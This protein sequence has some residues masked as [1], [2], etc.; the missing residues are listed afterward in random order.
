MASGG[1]GLNGEPS[2]QPPSGAED[3]EVRRS[4][5]RPAPR[6]T[7]F[8]PRKRANTACQVCRA[9]KTK[10][11]NKKPSCTY[12]LSVGAKC[13]QSPVDLSSFDPASLKILE[14]LDDLERFLRES[15]T[16]QSGPKEDGES[17]RQEPES[18]TRVCHDSTPG[19][20]SLHPE[21]DLSE[22]DNSHTRDYYPLRSILPPR[23]EDMLQWPCFS[24]DHLPE[25]TLPTSSPD[26]GATP[27]GS[28]GG[29]GAL[30]SEP[31]DMDPQW[32]NRLLDNFFMYVHCKNPILDETSTRKLVRRA[33]F[34]GIDWSPASCL[35][36]L[37]CAL[38]CVSGPFRASPELSMDSPAY[39]SSQVFFQAA[40]K[41]I[42]TLLVQS[43]IIGAQCLFFSGVYMMTVF[44]PMLAWRFFSQALAACQNFPFLTRAQTL[45]STSAEAHEAV[46]MS[47]RDTREQAVYWSAWKSERELSAELYLPDFS[48]LNSGSTLYPPFFPTP[49]DPAA[50]SP[51]AAPD[52]Q[53]QRERAA[54]LFYLSEISLRRLNS[55][56]CR[57]ILTLRKRHKLTTCFLE[58]LSTAIPDYEVQAAAWTNGLPPELSIHDTTGDDVCRAILRGHLV[59]LFELIYWPFVMATLDGTRDWLSHSATRELAYRG[60]ETHVNRLLV[61]EPGFFHRHHGT[62][63]MIKACTRSAMVL[64]AAARTGGL[65][66]PGWD[67][68]V[69]KATELL[70]Y[71]ANDMPDLARWKAILER[72]HVTSH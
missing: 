40:Q 39:G 69:L 3:L 46:E 8:Y 64:I 12:C 2:E 13:I 26:S 41:R 34:E 21:T 52:A 37:V 44:R 63:F 33:L 29:A 31:T 20:N 66:P 6:G 42:G 59:N 53:R 50:E 43:D 56:L 65:M 9:R 47:G 60:L 23:V 18:D 70:G 48:L 68:A 67:D 54:W 17:R 24:V 11:D 57:E 72:H 45:S 32:I 51:D 7:A 38:G 36:M 28:R 19:N 4:R 30:L 25:P 1:G 49:P 14:R 16:E 62:L 5:K 55:R 71:W 22:A 61:N 58:A 10:C 27:S 15:K 35:A